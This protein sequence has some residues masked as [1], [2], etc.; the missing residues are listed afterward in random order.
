[1]RAAREILLRRL[2]LYGVF[3][4]KGKAAGLPAHGEIG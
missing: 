3:G 1:M 2:W 4:A